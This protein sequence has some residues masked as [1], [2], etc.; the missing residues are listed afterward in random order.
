M[1][2]LKGSYYEMGLQY[3]VL[4]RPEILEALKAYK[5]VLTWTAKDM[6]IP[7]PILTA[8]LKFRS[9][10]MA[11]LLPQRFHEEIKGVS[12]GSGIPEDAIMM[13][14]LLYDIYMSNGCTGLLMRTS[15][16]KIIHGHNQ[17]P[18]GFGYEGLLGTYTV[19]VRYNPVGYNV[20][21]HIDPPLFLG[22]ETGYNNKGL[23][24][25]EETYSIR[26]PNPD[27]FPIVYLARIALE[28]SATLEEVWQLTSKFSVAASGGTIWSDR[29]TGRGARI[30]LLPTAR[31]YQELGGTILWDF[32]NIVDSE[33]A[34]QQHPRSNLAGFNKD[35]EQ[36]ANAFPQKNEYTMLDAVAFLRSRYAQDGSDY[37]WLGTR[38][39]I[40]NAWGQ[41]M[42]IFSP[43]GNG[44]YM[45]L[46]KRFAALRAVYHFGED[47]SERP[48]LFMEAI[49][50]SKIIEEA[51][52]IN[53]SLMSRADR[54]QA[55]MN[56]AQTYP[57][58]ANSY[59]LV[60]YESFQQSRWESFTFYAERAYNLAPSVPE[61]RLYAGLAAYHERNFEKA[62]EYLE[63]INYLNFPFST[64]IPTL[65]MNK[66]KLS[67][68]QE[69]YRLTALSRAWTAL[70]PQ[71]SNQYDAEIQVIL[72]NY[73]AVIYY[74][75]NI[76]AK[77][78]ELDHK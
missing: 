63:G 3:G 1:L 9:K 78:D 42:V 61:F 77:L 73:E 58:D 34:E 26:K 59:F 30:E 12:H 10:K 54:L 20:V 18:Y 69:L 24:Y 4:L 11:N 23:T 72:E 57:E 76:L 28:E 29:D 56:L 55:Y 15:D 51:A 19:V 66:T 13:V 71:R 36:L 46:G 6:G 47:F 32:N 53:T 35:R 70:D 16:G 22:V 49:P 75:R 68:E 67:P 17:E 52:K 65:S 48:A 25:T 44:F 39:A 62:I 74:D 21:T 14:S 2:E 33:L 38:S 43:D 50:I 37:T 27:G 31:A 5:K 40:A 45:A 8:I 60:S 64:S 7:L 41:Q